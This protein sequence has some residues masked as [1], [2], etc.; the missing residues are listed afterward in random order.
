[1]RAASPQNHTA[2]RRSRRSCPAEPGFGVY[3]T[4]R[5]FDDV[6]TGSGRLSYDR[7]CRRRRGWPYALRADGCDR[8]RR[9]RAAEEIRQ[10]RARRPGDLSIHGIPQYQLNTCFVACEAETLSLGRRDQEIDNLR[11]FRLAFLVSLEIHAGGKDLNILQQRSNL[12]AL[13]RVRPR[14]KA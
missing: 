1:M 2:D 14:R 8:L 5:H 10:D 4:V 11:L 13:E 3:R 6:R 7:W 12:R 9:A